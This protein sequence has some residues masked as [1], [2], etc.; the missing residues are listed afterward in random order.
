MLTILPIRYVADVA[1]TTAFYE[2]LGLRHDRAASFAP[3]YQHLQVGAGALGIHDAGASKGRP[4]GTV[5]LNFMTDEPL[6]EVAARLAEAGYAFTLHDEDFGRS[7][8]VVDPDG[9]M[10]QIQRIDPDVSRRSAGELAG[11]AD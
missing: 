1:A 5:E 11:A 6:D 8:R 9:I 10:V 4:I 2:G 3:V 7:L